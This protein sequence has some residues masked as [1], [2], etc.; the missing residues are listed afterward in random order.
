MGAGAAWHEAIQ[1]KPKPA[2]TVKTVHWC[3]RCDNYW[4][5]SCARLCDDPD[6]PS[7]TFRQTVQ[8]TFPPPRQWWCGHCADSVEAEVRQ[9]VL[10]QPSYSEK[11]QYELCLSCSMALRS[12]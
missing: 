2:R 11:K 5:P 8:K 7:N 12:L 6:D 10:N 9:R 3:R 4:M 1:A